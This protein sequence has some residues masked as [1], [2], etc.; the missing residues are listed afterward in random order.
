MIKKLTVLLFAALLL[1]LCD[2]PGNAQHF[3]A[4][5]E[6]ERNVAGF[7]Y[8]V[9]LNLETKRKF[10]IGGFY[11]CGIRQFEDQV[12]TVRPFYALQLQLPLLNS[13]KVAILLSTKT[14]F[15]NNQFLVFVP[16]I[17]TTVQLSPLL[18]LSFGSGF[19]MQHAS[20]IARINLTI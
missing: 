6:I 13:D 12:T 10:S 1:V 4:S 17:I 20:M 16:A 15:V 5:T 9:S 19:R 8:G 2:V 7:H 3:V 11:Q 18:G 14:G